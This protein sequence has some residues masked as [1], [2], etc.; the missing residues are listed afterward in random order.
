MGRF[1]VGWGGEDGM[2][3]AV[4]SDALALGYSSSYSVFG[5]S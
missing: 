1:F 4:V 5:V 3:E 2:L